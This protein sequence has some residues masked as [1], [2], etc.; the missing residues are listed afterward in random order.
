MRSLGDELYVKYGD[1]NREVWYHGST[2]L[3]VLPLTGGGWKRH[4]DGGE[5]SVDKCLLGQHGSIAGQ[6]TTESLGKRRVPAA[7]TWDFAEHLGQGEL[8][9]IRDEDNT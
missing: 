5:E 7:L 3:N 1:I 6:L 4:G 9:L 8:R 2:S